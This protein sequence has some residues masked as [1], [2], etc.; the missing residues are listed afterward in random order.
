MEKLKG[1]LNQLDLPKI[2]TTGNSK[3]VKIYFLIKDISTNATDTNN[4]NKILVI[5]LNA[6]EVC[7]KDINSNYTIIMRLKCNKDGS[8]RQIT[9]V[10]E[11]LT[12]FNPEECQNI[13]EASSIE[14]IIIP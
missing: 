14:G 8:P 12:K 7:K 6:G 11:S 2:L 3:Q 9:W 13:L 1:V 10:P 4:T 5:G